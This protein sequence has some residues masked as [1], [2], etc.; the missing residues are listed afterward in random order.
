VLLADLV[1]PVGIPKPSNPLMECRLMMIKQSARTRA[2]KNRDNEG[3]E[4][5]ASEYETSQWDA[6]AIFPGIIYAE[7][8]K[9]GLWIS[10]LH[11]EAAIPPCRRCMLPALQR[12]VQPA[13]SQQL[14]LI[15]FLMSNSCDCVRGPVSADQSN[16]R[17]EEAASS[18]SILRRERW[19]ERELTESDSASYI[20]HMSHVWLVLQ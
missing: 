11:P 12:R 10:T 3:V 1:G 20:G 5:K 18:L 13:N 9:Q 8:I 19:R 2:R 4:M 14:S 16:V 7:L 15:R 6:R 17:P